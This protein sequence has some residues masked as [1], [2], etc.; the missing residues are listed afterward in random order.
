LDNINEINGRST[1]PDQR[2]KDFSEI[3]AFNSAS[4]IY[5]SKIGYRQVKHMNEQE[6]NGSGLLL[7]LLNKN[8]SRDSRLLFSYHLIDRLSFISC[9]S[10]GMNKTFNYFCLPNVSASK[11]YPTKQK[12]R[13]TYTIFGSIHDKIWPKFTFH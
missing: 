6:I 4:V 3:R 12:E 1:D 8:A 7:F 5:K 2:L 9:N 11:M 10:S 13:M